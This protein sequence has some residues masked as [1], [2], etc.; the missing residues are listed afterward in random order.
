MLKDYQS[1]K[2]QNRTEL[3]KLEEIKISLESEAKGTRVQVEDQAWS[4]IEGLVE[5]NKNKL[6][7]QIESGIIAKQ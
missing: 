3:A 1:E 5:S 4:S 6:N 7:V 2:E